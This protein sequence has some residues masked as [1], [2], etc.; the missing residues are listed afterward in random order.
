MDFKD[1][2]GLNLELN[3]DLEFFGEGSSF[4]DDLS[5]EFELDTEDLSDIESFGRFEADPAGGLVEELTDEF[6][7]GPDF[8]VIGPDT[9]K[10]IGNTRSVPWR[11]IV[12]ITPPGCTGTL[13]APNKVL[14]A[15][16]CVY[17]RSNKRRYSG[18]RVIPGKNGSRE[19]F[20]SARAV[21][22]N[23][24]SAYASAS[25]YGQAWPHDYAVITL[26]KPIGR[27]IGYWS[28]IAALS[29]SRLLRIKLNTAGYPGDKG[30]QHMYWTYNRVVSVRGPRIEYLHDTAGGQSGSPVW[31]RHRS[32][33]TIVA[34]H[35]AR[36]DSATS[37]VANRGVAITPAILRQIR[38]WVRS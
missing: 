22:I 12:K 6:D 38:A 16:H 3:D 35:V 4:E 37:V 15:A 8:Q 19:P 30:G 26:D 5:A 27:R 18:I 20:G 9:R 14:T 24:P 7:P 25:T 2:E 33:R 31:L 10:R 23:Y 11:H 13:I 1:S 17:N 34:V 28:R 32:A 29:P 21:R 36:D